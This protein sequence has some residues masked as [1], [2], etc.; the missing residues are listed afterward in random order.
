ME[1]RGVEADLSPS[2]MSMVF[3]SAVMQRVS[4]LSDHLATAGDK[5][6]WHVPPPP[7]WGLGPRPAPVPPPSEVWEDLQKLF[8]SPPPFTDRD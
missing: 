3:L 1:D 7:I 8:L 4:W 6:T 2:Q 5:A